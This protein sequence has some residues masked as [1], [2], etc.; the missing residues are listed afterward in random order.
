V[1]VK[2]DGLRSRRNSWRMEE[3]PVPSGNGISVIQR[4]ATSHAL[5]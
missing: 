2:L 4:A 1:G 5:T 3:V